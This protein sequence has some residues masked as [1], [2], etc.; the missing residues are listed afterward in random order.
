[1]ALQNGTWTY[2]PSGVLTA[3]TGTGAPT[4]PLELGGGSGRRRALRG[5][6]L[7][8]H[9]RSRLGGQTRGPGATGLLPHAPERHQVVLPAVGRQLA[10]VGAVQVEEL[11][12][13]MQPRAHAE[14]D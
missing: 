7:R 10:V 5:A 13:L 4:G 8:P 11:A 1:M 3:S 12:H 2:R 6:Q 14:A 9:R